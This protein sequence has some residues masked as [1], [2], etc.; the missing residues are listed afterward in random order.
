MLQPFHPLPSAANN[1]R[2]EIAPYSQQL[3]DFFTVLA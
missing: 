3:G 1:A 2:M